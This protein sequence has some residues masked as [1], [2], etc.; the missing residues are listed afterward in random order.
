MTE[1][2]KRQIR[3]LAMKLVSCLVFI[4]ILSYPLRNLDIISQSH[5]LFGV[6]I[7]CLVMRGIEVMGNLIVALGT[8]DKPELPG[9]ELGKL[10]IDRL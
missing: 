1:T 8:R 6:V 2:K 4:A 9:E 10:E 7:G 5:V 3:K